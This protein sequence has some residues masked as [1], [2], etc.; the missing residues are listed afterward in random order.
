MQMSEPKKPM[1]PQEE[2][3]LIDKNLRKKRVSATTSARLFARRGKLLKSMGANDAVAPDD[4]NDRAEK[5]GGYQFTDN[6]KRVLNSFTDPV[7]REMWENVYRSEAENRE[8]FGTSYD[9]SKYKPSELELLVD[10]FREKNRLKL[11]EDVVKYGPE[12][13]GERCV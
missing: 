6:E 2:L 11:S 13:K 10:S 12:G 4:A 1:T 8:K 7:E 5:T 9:P 3:E